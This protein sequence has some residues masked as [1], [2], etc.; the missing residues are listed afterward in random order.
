MKRVKAVLAA[1]GA[2]VVM[3]VMATSASASADIFL[4]IPGI[5]GETTHIVSTPSGNFHLN[6]LNGDPCQSGGSPVA[7]LTPRLNPNCVTVT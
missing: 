3:A 6:F 4:T 2:M 1:V 5:P 7:P